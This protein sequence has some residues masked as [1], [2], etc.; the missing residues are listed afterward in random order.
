MRDYL[1]E[2]ERQRGLEVGR[3]PAFRSI[4]VSAELEKMP[5]DQLPALLIASPGTEASAGARGGRIEAHGDGGYLARFRVDCAAVIS[6][7]G[8]RQ[9]PR[10]ARLYAVA[11]GALLVQQALQPCPLSIR[12]V[13]WVSDSYALMASDADRTQSG[14]IVRI[15]VEVA[16]VKTG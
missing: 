8:N 5:E 7:R 16:D 10:L 11:L 15:G 9:A 6:A 13:D 1:A 3:L 12:R 14:G 2:I 4:V